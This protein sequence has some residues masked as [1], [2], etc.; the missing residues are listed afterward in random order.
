MDSDIIIVGG[1]AAGMV[2]AYAAAKSGAS[3]T[4]LEKMPRPGRKIMISGKGRCNMTNLKDWNEFSEH[5]HPKAAFLKNAFYNFSSADTLEFFRENGLETVTERG[6][7]V[8][9]ASYKA[10]DVVDTLLSAAKKAGASVMTGSEVSG[11]SRDDGIFTLDLVSG[12]RMTAA[13]IIIATGGLSYP[14]TG[15][16][17]DGYRWAA[18]FGHK[19]RHCFPSLTALVPAD[20]KVSGGIP[21]GKGHISRDL[22]PSELGKTLM[23][24]Q[25]KNISLT[26]N[27]DGHTVMEEFGDADFTDG[28]LE[29]PAGF[30]IS[31]KCVNALENGSKVTVFLDLKPA[32]KQESLDRRIENLWEEISVDSRSRRKSQ[33]ERFRILLG[34][35]MPSGLVNAFL[36]YHPSTDVRRLGKRMKNWEFRIAGYVGYERCVVTAGGISTDGISQKTMESKLVPGLYFAGEVLDLDGDTGG[37]NLQTAFSTGFLAG[38][39]AALK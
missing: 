4:V 19:I 39:S 20:Y 37:Y 7:R 11:I 33:D 36:R 26:V 14:A 6:D 31:R 18:G 21:Q 25:L 3:V 29:G 10:S 13:K 22:P 1:G 38:R 17:G 35:L 8:F 9:P 32:V 15:S 5:I 34:K 16:T 28:G 12:K 24:N 2:A 23:G 27:I 30:R